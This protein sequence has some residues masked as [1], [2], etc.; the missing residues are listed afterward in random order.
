MI[1]QGQVCS[2]LLLD[3]PLTALHHWSHDPSL[4]AKALMIGGEQYTAVELLYAI[5]EEAHKFVAAG[6]AGGL[7]PGVDEIMALWGDS[8]EKL[9]RS[10]WASM[11]GRCDWIAKKAF[12]DRAIQ[13]HNLA[14]DSPAVRHLDQIYG[15]LD[16]SEGLYWTLEKAGRAQQLATDAVIEKFVHKAPEDT[17]A[18]LRGYILEHVDP[19]LIHDVDW[20]KIQFRHEE[21]SRD[22]WTRYT[23]PT[24]R[25]DHPAQFSRQACE[26]VI[27]G[28]PTLAA[29]LQ[30]LGMRDHTKSAPA[31]PAP[32]SGLL[33]I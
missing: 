15:S 21:P 5:F 10:D 18:W 31:L 28:A 16:A 22:S 26:A 2:R 30:A 17:R 8:L 6:R 29:A 4:Q 20:D 12:L 9:Q 33:D 1:E 7:V 13:Q 24:L 27:T 11:A 32:T 23:Y 14:W 3:D 19:G 25:M